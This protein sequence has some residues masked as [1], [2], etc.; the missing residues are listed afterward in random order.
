[1]QSESL[2]TPDSSWLYEVEKSSGVKVSACYQC[3]KCSSGCP[4][5]FAM[6]YLP[7]KLLHMIQMGLKDE[8]LKSAT[9]WVCASCET[10]TTRC[11]NDI[12][13]ARIMDVMR[14]ESLKSG[15]ATGEKKV[16]VFH[17]AFL[18]SIE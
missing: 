13:I 11:P 7:N 14:R 8:V 18:S 12:D 6:D 9:I 5:T 4:V 17:D 10:C 15:L 2:I 1:M 3:K 16:P